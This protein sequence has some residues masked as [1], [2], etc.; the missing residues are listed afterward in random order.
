MRARLTCTSENLIYV[1]TCRGCRENYIG[2]TGDTLPHRMTVHKQQI[3]E[4]KYQCTSVSGHIR[5]C[6]K[7]L[8]PN[9]YIF[10][11]YKFYGKSTEK[12]REN[13]KKNI[14]LRNISHFWMQHNHKILIINFP[15]IYIRTLCLGINDSKALDIFRALILCAMTPRYIVCIH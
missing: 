8:F 3:R 2:Q 7:N 1:M 6:A 5:N 13:N 12:E 15:A 4:P 9:F 14:L 10:P 11:L